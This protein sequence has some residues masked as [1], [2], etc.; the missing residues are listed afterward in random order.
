MSEA[1]CNNLPQRKALGLVTHDNTGGPFVVECQGCGEVYPSFHCL[2]GGQIADTGDHEDARCP[3]CEQVGPEECDNAALAWNT[4]QLRINELQQRLT[5]ADQRIDELEGKLAA[6]PPQAD[7]QI[8]GDAIALTEPERHF[9]QALRENVNRADAQPVAK[10]VM[11]LEAERLWG[12]A[13]EYGVS[14][15][16]QQWLQACRKTGGEFLL[17]THADAGEVERLRAGLATAQETL[18]RWHDLNLKREAE[19]DTLRAQLDTEAA[20]HAKTLAEVQRL[21]LMVSQSDYNYDMDRAEF[22]R[23][24][25]ERDALLRDCFDAMLKGG[26]SKPLRERIKVALADSTD[27]VKP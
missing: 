15:V 14:I 27:S 5:T 9:V 12:G 26:Y 23:Q 16:D 18:E 2:G 1:H 21:D 8:V 11:K 25:A 20:N 19:R 10:P 22:K 13:G 24:L 6:V 17:Y 3:H 4:Q 7:A